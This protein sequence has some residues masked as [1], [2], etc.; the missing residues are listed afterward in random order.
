M[1]KYCNNVILFFKRYMYNGI[2]NV[3]NLD[4]NE[5]LEL[6]EACDELCF[7][8]LIEDL[9]NFLMKEEKEWIQENLIDIYKI[10]AKHQSFNLLQDYC[11]ELIYCDNAELLLKSKDI[12]VIEKPMLMT[13]LKKDDLELREIDIWDC[14]IRW[15]MGQVE[16]LEQLKRIEEI[17]PGQHLPK[18]KKQKI[19]LE[20][21]NILEL[22]KD[23]LKELK[24]ILGDIIP[25]VRFNQITSTEFHKEIEPY[26]KIIDKELYEEIIQI[27]HNNSNDNWQPRL[28]LQ[29][30]PRIKEGKL[31]NSRMKYLISGWIDLKKYFYKEDELPYGFQLIHQGTKDGFS[32]TIFEQKCY[33]IEQTLVL[34]KIK[35]TGE[36]IGGYNPVYWNKKEKSLNDFYWIKTDKSFT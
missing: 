24:D 15:G 9:Q 12:V 21:E 2:I 4:A 17:E 20:K 11:D 5:I 18:F 31:L 35:E 27:Y 23:H 1:I 25:L 36:L 19:K 13:I 10:S 34:M 29:R 33:N 14:V 32:R 16:N 3:D 6:L 8:E 30:C 22:N 7:D 28:L 26:K